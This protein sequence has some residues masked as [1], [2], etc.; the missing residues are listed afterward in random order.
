MFEAIHILGMKNV[1]GRRAILGTA[2]HAG[3]AAF[4]TA[5]LDGSPISVDDAV[6]VMVDKLTNPDSDFDSNKDSLSKREAEIIGITLT[7]KYCHEWAPKYD[8][9]AVEMSVNPLDIDCGNGIVIR[10]TGTLDRARIY[11]RDDSTGI[12]DLKTGSRAVIE[13]KKPAF[14]RPVPLGMEHKLGRTSSYLLTQ[15]DKK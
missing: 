4:D 8:Y 15:R 14:T 3:T 11:K 5:R 13:D 6:G 1:V 9:V 2:I 7:A 10:L 12:N